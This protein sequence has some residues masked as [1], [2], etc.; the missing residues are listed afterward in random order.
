MHSYGDNLFILSSILGY[1]LIVSC[2]YKMGITQ[3]VVNKFV[4]K[5]GED[6]VEKH[7]S[8]ESGSRR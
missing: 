8:V 2:F 3:I 6:E 5:E 7:L 1:I 4:D